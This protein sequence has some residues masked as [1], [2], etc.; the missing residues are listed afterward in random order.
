MEVYFKGLK[1]DG[2]EK[3]IGLKEALSG[4][5][6]TF[7]VLLAA[8]LLQIGT[9]VAPSTAALIF[10]VSSFPGVRYIKPDSLWIFA[11][12]LLLYIGLYGLGV[13]V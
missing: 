4:I 9:V 6:A 10:A 3:R 8:M 13:P 12:G 11:G 2:R 7:V 5:R 1:L